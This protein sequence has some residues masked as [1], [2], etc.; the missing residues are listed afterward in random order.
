MLKSLTKEFELL[1][2]LL[3]GL[4]GC[5]PCAQRTI[6]GFFRTQTHRLSQ[7]DERTYLGIVGHLSLRLG[8]YG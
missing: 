1:V 5:G 7:R 4:H 8:W 2:D 3:L 6:Q